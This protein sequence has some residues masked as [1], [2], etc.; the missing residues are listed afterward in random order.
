[1]DY[2]GIDPVQMVWGEPRRRPFKGYWVRWFEWLQQTYPNANHTLF[3]GARD[4]TPVQVLLPCIYAYV[5][6][7]AD[8]IFLELGSMLYHHARDNGAIEAVVRKLLALRPRPTLCFLTVPLWC[9]CRPFCRVSA[10]FGIKKLPNYSYTLLDDTH[11]ATTHTESAVIER[12]IEALCRHYDLSCISLRQAIYPQVALGLPG[13][14]PRDIAG[15]C[16]HPVHGR[17]GFDYI[18]ELL[19]YWSNTSAMLAHE[20]AAR[21]TR[22]SNFIAEH[23]WSKHARRAT[24]QLPELKSSSIFLPNAAH[25]AERKLTRQANHL[26]RQVGN[27]EGH[28]SRSRSLWM[29]QSNKRLRRHIVDGLPQLENHSSFS[30]LPA[31]LRPHAKHMATAVA[32]C[33]GLEELGSRGTSNGRNLLTVPW[34]TASCGVFPQF[35]ATNFEKVSRQNGRLTSDG[36]GFLFGYKHFCDAVDATPSCP[37]AGLLLAKGAIPPRVWVFCSHSLGSNPKRSPGVVA[38]RPGA[39][40]YLPLELA[41]VPKHAAVS[42]VR[43]SLLHLTSYEGMGIVRLRCGGSCTCEQQRVDAHQVSQTRNVSVFIEHSFRASLHHSQ[44]CPLFVWLT[45]ESSSGGHK[46]KLRGVTAHASSHR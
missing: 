26:S 20:T 34:H 3:N 27:D 29:W 24:T 39:L 41:F 35:R 46:F 19:V 6:P 36:M 25:L 11:R 14:S 16:L 4:A 12:N 7:N 17:R 37:K 32:A 13:F 1:M 38:L 23:E 44:S 22:P 9:K 21:A 5:P 28:T 33:Y 18:T 15:D 42:H 31:P 43:I 45:N 2:R 30:D 8:L 40:L 10:P